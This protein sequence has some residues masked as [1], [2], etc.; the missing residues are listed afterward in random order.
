MSRA[1]RNT[2]RMFGND[3][4]RMTLVRSCS[5]VSFI[6]SSPR[7]KLEAARGAALDK[8]R[9]VEIESSFF[10]SARQ[11]S[12]QPFVKEMYETLVV[13]QSSSLPSTFK[14]TRKSGIFRWEAIL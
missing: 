3:L 1:T 9:G 10:R 2:R 8:E 7:G 4:T 13:N 11:P 6:K 12:A 14:G 5:P